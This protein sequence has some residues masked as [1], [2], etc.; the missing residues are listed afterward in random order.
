VFSGALSPPGRADFPGKAVAALTCLSAALVAALV[1]VPSR[2]AAQ[3][4]T[5]LTDPRLLA[6]DLQDAFVA[7]WRSGESTYPPGLAR[8]VDYWARYS[9]LEAVITS[10]LLVTLVALGRL[11]WKTY[12]RGEI[13]G[14]ANRLTIASASTVVWGCALVALWT[15]TSSIQDAFA[16]FA[17]VLPVLLDGSAHEALAQT[18]DRVQQHL[19]PSTSAGEPAPPALAAMVDG[20]ARFHVVHAIAAAP[21]TLYLLGAGVR[22]WRR[23]TRVSE[24]HVRRTVTSAAAV[25][26]LLSFLF[27]V[28]CAVNVGTAIDPE[29]SLYGLFQGG[30]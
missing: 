13:S 14:R 19:A 22:L 18:L 1:L 29:P 7:Y 11:L 5:R 20:N 8:V 3:G 30:W 26:V 6:Q 15:L 16:P 9:I 25:C 24:R 10:A 21:T 27:G 17:A 23:R 2:I 28:I 12:M 4:D